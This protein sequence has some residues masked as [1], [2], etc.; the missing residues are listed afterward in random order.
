MMKTNKYYNKNYR[1][2]NKNQKIKRIALI[3]NYKVKYQLIY[4]KK[5]LINKMNNIQKK[6]LKQKE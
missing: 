5:E 6:Y 4:K 2:N 1:Y 3:K